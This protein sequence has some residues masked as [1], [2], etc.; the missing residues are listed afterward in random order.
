VIVRL[1]FVLVTITSG[2]GLIIYPVLWMVM[3]QAPPPEE[4]PVPP[5]GLPPQAA[6]GAE[7]ELRQPAPWEP[8]AVRLREPAPHGSIRP[9]APPFA[10]QPPPPE[11]YRF[12]PLTGERIQREAPATGATTD[13][14][15]RPA[16]E[17]LAA[18]QGGESAP[19]PKTLRGRVS[20]AGIILVGMGVM[21]LAEQIGIDPDIMFPVLMVAVGAL[22]LLRR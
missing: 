9:A 17:P 11:E 5:D 2:F 14:S 15:R 20:W 16:A 13:L 8:Q 22:L 12:D 6:L 21:L 1:V 18:D 3:P 10:D 4:Q 19:A 7:Q